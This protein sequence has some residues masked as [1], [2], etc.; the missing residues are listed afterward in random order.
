ML[1]SGDD[2]DMRRF[3]VAFACLLVLPMATSSAATPDTL[4]PL[5]KA[6]EFEY[7][8][9]QPDTR[10][11]FTYE[12]ALKLPA[13]GSQP[14]VIDQLNI[15]LARGT[16]VDLGAIPACTADDETI[17]AQGVVICPTRSRL[18]AGEAAIWTG[19]GPLLHLSVDAFST[20][21]GVVVVLESQGTVVAV[22]RA[23]L[24]GTRLTVTVPPIDLAPGVQAAI[25]HFNLP[26]SGGSTRRPVFTTPSS[27]GS[28]GWRIDYH[29]HFARVG[30]VSLAYVT[31]CQA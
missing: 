3:L 15:A 14:P 21:H 7:T 16:R 9:K 27:C 1:R 30:R 26:L 31:K 6:F 8:S 25:V 12:F 22:I 10:T 11:G 19:S 24:K 17:T 23:V 20:G 13:D 18:G 2:R 4:N 5:F 28:A 29:P